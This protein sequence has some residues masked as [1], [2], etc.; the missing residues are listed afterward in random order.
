M[1]QFVSQ[2]AAQDDYHALLI[3]Q[4]MESAGAE[5]FAVTNDAIGNILVYC[6]YNDHIDEAW[7]D[8][9]VREVVAEKAAHYAAA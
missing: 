4:G 8:K 9:K 3:A 5:V 2:R 7:I 1:K 6:K